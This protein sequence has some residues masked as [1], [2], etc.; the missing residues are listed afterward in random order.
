MLKHLRTIIP[1]TLVLT[2]VAFFS[3][4]ALEPQFAKA[5]TAQVVI[6]LNV[7]QGISLTNSGN[8]T[9]STSLGIAQNTAVG[10][11]TWTVIT[12]DGAGYTLALT[13]T[14]TPA[15]Q[16]TT[17][18]FSITD[19]QKGAPNLWSATTSNAYF[20]YSA[21]GTDTLTSDWG[22]G[23]NCGVGNAISTTLKYQ[24]LATTSAAYT[25]QKNVASR[26]A[27]TTPA[28]IVTT[29]C[30]A[31]EQNNFFIPAATYNATVIGTATPL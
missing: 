21:F 24:G 26:A 27:T 13:S 31:V 12:N 11:T 20:G 7:T 17:G 9:M 3:W 10:T 14:S 8:S 6:T 28:G 15:M 29:T 30:Y 18:G 2:L 16:S 23:A 22:T 4:G 19:Y 5:V 1:T 25:V